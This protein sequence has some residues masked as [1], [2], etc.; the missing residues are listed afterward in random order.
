MM[1]K[2]FFGIPVTE[3]EGRNFG[4]DLFR[5]VAVLLVLTS[6]TLLGFLNSEALRAFIFYLGSAGVDLFF[7]LSGFLIGTILI[8][9]HNKEKVTTF[10]S[11]KGFWI[12]R[13]FRTLPNYLLILVIYILFF[14]FYSLYIP[15]H[16]LPLYLTFLQN[17]F[18]HNEWFYGVAW[19]LSVE[20][21]F[22]L[23]FPLVLLVIQH[24][25]LKSKM[26]IVVISIFCF[27]TACLLLRIMV[28]LTM[29]HEWDDGFRKQMPLRLDSIAIGVLAAVIKFYYQD[30]WLNN[31]NKMVIAGTCLL[32]VLTAEMYHS[33]LKNNTIYGSLFMNTVFFTLF[34]LALAMLLPFVHAIRLR[35]FKYLRYSITYISLISYSIYLIHPLFSYLVSHYLSG[36]LGVWWLM[37]ILWVC[38]FVSSSLIYN[39]FEK[40][41]TALRERFAEAKEVSPVLS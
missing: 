12:R 7:V 31:K 9:I 22:Y 17:A 21:W 37:A 1:A 15:Y 34:S 26:R 3:L 10:S 23:L 4:L 35:S 36:K 33:L 28:S 5:C 39:L 27:L 16:K 30:F 41:I 38:V 40:R 19:S 2:R 29:H 13:W 18:I 11:I 6:H 14:K 24:F 8:K 25:F 20:E 32:T